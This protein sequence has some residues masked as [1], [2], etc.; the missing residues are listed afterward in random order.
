MMVGRRTAALVI[1]AVALAGCGTPTSEHPDASRDARSLWSARSPYVGDNSRMVALVREV[2]PAP[3]GSYRIELQT[4][5]PPYG[6]T[7]GLARLDKPFADTD[8]GESATLLLGLVANLDK[9][10]VTSGAHAY[11]LTSAGA[12]AQLGYDVKELG[13]DQGKLR[14]YLE[15]TR[16]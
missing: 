3:E 2:G 16:D 15:S 10:S 12:S 6:M 13:R 4:D 8:F 14:A 9:V 11:S 7:V 1:V 5:R